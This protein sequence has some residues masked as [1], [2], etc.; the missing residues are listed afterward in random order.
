[1]AALVKGVK[2]GF[3]R[4]VRKEKFVLGKSTLLK[5]IH[6]RR[7]TRK[8]KHAVAG[9]RHQGGYVRGEEPNRERGCASTEVPERVE[10]C[11]T[12]RSREG[13]ETFF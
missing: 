12:R 3:G 10:E 13:R 9:T 6:T 5:E 7:K 2:R 4:K 11:E 1:M 8:R